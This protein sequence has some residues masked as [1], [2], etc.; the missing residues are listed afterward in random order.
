M[1]TPLSSIALSHLSKRRQNRKF[2]ATG[3][4]P[5]LT[6]SAHF[7]N[8]HCLL[9]HDLRRWRCQTSVP[10]EEITARVFVPDLELKIVLQNLNWLV[11]SVN[12]QILKCDKGHTNN[13]KSS[14]G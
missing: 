7:P 12:D 9:Q 13:R 2:E 1:N 5:F 10:E 3:T 8:L 6:F 14:V 4:F 11:C